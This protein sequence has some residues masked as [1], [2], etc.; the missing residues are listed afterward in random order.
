MCK[1]HWD[2]SGYR[3]SCGNQQGCTDCDESGYTWCNPT[4]NECDTVE[5]EENGDSKR[6][7]RCDKGKKIH[8]SA[9]IGF[10][11]MCNCCATA[12]LKVN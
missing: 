4:N 3:D 10:E 9:D 6:W 2:R 7:F 11:T 12:R 8:L 5:R 1:A